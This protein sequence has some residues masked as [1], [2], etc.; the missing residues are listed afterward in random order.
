MIADD[1][2]DVAQAA[3]P[4]GR[5]DD[6]QRQ[7]GDRQEV[8]GDAHQHRVGAAAEV[9]RRAR[10][11][12]RRSASRRAAAAKPTISETRAPYII[13]LSMSKPPSSSPSQ[14]CGRRGREHVADALV[15]AVGRDPGGED[16]DQDDDQRARCRRT[17][18]C[19]ARERRHDTALSR[20]LRRGATTRPS[21]CASACD[22]HSTIRGSSVTYSRSAIR[23]AITIDDVM[24]RNAPCSIG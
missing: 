4:D 9:A 14:C 13:R 20:S 6:H 22:A 10:R 24:I 2:D 1:Q 17:C 12:R 16:G 18:A 15:L 3:A 5:H 23:F 19:R 8:V 7:V 11:P 21:A